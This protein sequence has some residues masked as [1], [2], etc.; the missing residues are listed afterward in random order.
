MWVDAKFL[1]IRGRLSCYQQSRLFESWIPGEALPTLKDAY[2]G[3]LQLEILQAMLALGGKEAPPTH[4]LL[5]IISN[6]IMIHTQ[7]AGLSR[8]CFTGGKEVSAGLCAEVGGLEDE[9]LQAVMKSSGSWKE[10]HDEMRNTMIKT[11]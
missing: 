4:G 2:Q 6:L 1:S 5:Q 3:T 7:Q 10:H 9:F 8:P 11:P